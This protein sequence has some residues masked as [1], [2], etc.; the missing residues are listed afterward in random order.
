MY[1]YAGMPI[2]SLSPIMS[3]YKVKLLEN[4]V[5]V[6]AKVWIKGVDG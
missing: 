5:E 1:T 2:Y 4:V 3:F 6:G